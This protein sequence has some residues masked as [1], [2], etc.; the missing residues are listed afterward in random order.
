MP[1]NSRT[2]TKETLRDG[3]GEIDGAKGVAVLGALIFDC[4]HF[5]NVFWL[6]WRG[7]LGSSFCKKFLLLRNAGIG[8][9][10]SEF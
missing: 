6:F 1:G 7:G 3:N 2:K 10:N 9:Q 5:V 8:D 4:F